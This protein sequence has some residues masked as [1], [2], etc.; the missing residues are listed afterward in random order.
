MA[1]YTYQESCALKGMKLS[2]VS[3]ANGHDTAYAYNWQTQQSASATVNSYSESV[4]CRV[5]ETA[6][7]KCEVEHFQKTAA[8]KVEYND[9]YK[10]KY[11][12]SG[13]GYWLFIVPGVILKLTYDSE[14]SKAEAQSRAIAST[15]SCG[16]KPASK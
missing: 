8:P 13:L 16:P 3:E 2:G 1:P 5:A 7:D 6:A 14:L 15:S 10:G 11:F 12:L 9:G 4:A